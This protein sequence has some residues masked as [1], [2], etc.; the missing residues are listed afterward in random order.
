MPALPGSFRR[1]SLTTEPIIDLSR[2]ITTSPPEPDRGTRFVY[3]GFLLVG[4]IAVLLG[5]LIPELQAVWGID[6]AQTGT[7]FMMQFLASSIGGVLASL[8]LRRSIVS[9]Y[10]CA[11]LGLV[12]LIW[13]GWELARLSMAILGFALGL[14][15]TAS[16]LLVA[17]RNSANRGAA[18][19][20][21]NLS[22]GIGAVICPLLFAAFTAR[23]G[24]FGLV[25]LFATLAAGT[26]VVMALTLRDTP[27]VG[28]SSS[29][30]EPVRHA[31][32]AL[33]LLIAALLFLYVGVETSVGGWLVTLSDQLSVERAVVS[34][35]IGSGFWGA[36]LVGRTAAALLL[37]RIAEPT[38]YW[39]S[40]ATAA[41]GTAC[42]FLAESRAGI[43]AGA[44]LAGLGLASLFP[45]TVSIL[46]E[47][48]S[49]SR[50]RL[51]GSV[52]AFGGFGGAFLPWLTGRLARSGE[53]G[54]SLSHGFMVPL[55]GLALLSGLYLTY[56][57]LHAPRDAGA[58]PG[59]TRS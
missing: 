37:R 31:P 1:V 46:A 3:A 48:T 20:A 54:D 47:A 50:S 52:M 21:L 56:R 51:A 16:N 17:E 58:L 57:L 41:A 8:H 27:D 33:L 26:G 12:C 59:S 23:L 36:L 29:A 34:L 4:M 43:A 30:P 25:A 38:L 15:I 18:L 9:G 44:L 14:L 7:L 2:P 6:H 49:S 13:G 5:P 35:V 45:L 10:L 24:A 11:A 39:L 55:V 19:A 22:W 40:L 53:A 32:A 42:L 28:R